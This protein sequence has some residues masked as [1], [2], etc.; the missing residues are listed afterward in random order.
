[1]IRNIT[2]IGSLGELTACAHH[3]ELNI[4][5]YRHPSKETMRIMADYV[6]EVIASCRIA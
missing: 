6:E 2:S 3:S 1:M 4:T 5:L